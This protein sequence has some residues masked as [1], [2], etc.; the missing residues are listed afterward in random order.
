MLGKRFECFFSLLEGGF[1]SDVMALVCAIKC[2]IHLVAIFARFSTVMLFYRKEVATRCPGTLYDRPF[3]TR[4][5]SLQ[6]RGVNFDRGSFRFEEETR[7][8]K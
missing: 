1:T 6:L 8:I 2:P 7:K 4:G 5:S 3:C